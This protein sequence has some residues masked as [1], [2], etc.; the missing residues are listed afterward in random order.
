MRG[1]FYHSLVCPSLSQ[2]LF[3]REEKVYDEFYLGIST[4][5][6]PVA[7]RAN[8]GKHMANEADRSRL[9]GIVNGRSL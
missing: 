9:T 5:A 6:I 1:L 4:L 3:G 8:G 7:M 2:N